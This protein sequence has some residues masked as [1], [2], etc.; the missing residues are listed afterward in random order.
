MYLQISMSVRMKHVLRMPR[1]STLRVVS[2][3]GAIQ[4]SL[5]METTIAQVRLLVRSLQLGNKQH[6]VITPI[7][8][9]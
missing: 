1:A 3:V 8:R 6:Y 2:A 4:D 7:D 9:I 5:E